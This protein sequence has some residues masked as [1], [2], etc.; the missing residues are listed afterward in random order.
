MHNVRYLCP[1]DKDERTL[2]KAT[3]HDSDCQRHLNA[4]VSE[5]GVHILVDR[6]GQSH[7]PLPAHAIDLDM[8]ANRMCRVLTHETQR[9]HETPESVLALF[10]TGVVTVAV[11]GDAVFFCQPSSRTHPDNIHYEIRWW[12]GVVTQALIPEY[13]GLWNA[14]WAPDE[15]NGLPVALT[16]GWSDVPLLVQLAM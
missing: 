2:F 10:S 9:D 16:T 6:R 14:S 8:L 7:V 15:S 11:D 5:H 3:L 13:D 12:D 4:M 1:Q